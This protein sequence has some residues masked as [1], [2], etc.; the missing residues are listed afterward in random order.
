MKNIT[1]LSFLF[2]TQVCAAQKTHKLD[3]LFTQLYNQQQFNGNVLVME[4]GQ[5]ILKKSY[6]LADVAHQQ[7]L[8]ENSV[9]DVGSLTKQFTAMAIVLLKERNQLAYTDKLSKYIPELAFYGDITLKNLLNHT[10]G[11][12]DYMELMD[13][14]WDHKKIATNQDVIHL[15]QQAQ[16]SLSFTPSSKHEYS[17]T[18][19]LLLATVIERVSKQSYPEFLAKNIFK[20][21][22]MT[23]TLV[24]H[25]RLHPKKLKDYAYGYVFDNT[26][27]WVVAD[28]L[29]EMDYV[30]YLDGLYGEGAI[31]STLHD[32][33]KWY[34]AIKTHRLISPETLREITT[35]DPLTDGTPTGYSFGWRVINNDEQFILYHS[36]FWPGYVSYLEM[37]LKND[38]FF[39]VLQNF[40]NGMLVSKNIREILQD[41]PL[42]PIYKKQ[43]T[44]N[45]TQLQKWVGDYVDKEDNS[46]VHHIKMRDNRLVYNSTQQAWEMFFYPQSENK[47]FYK[48]NRMNLELEF[49]PTADHKTEMRL[50][51]NGQ[52]IGSALSK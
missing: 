50:L 14:K 3:S 23:H 28:S 34:N 4:K 35:P 36:G 40:H 16:D 32:L 1:I 2:I 46:A 49:V 41:K 30:T 24:Y 22:Q 48:S 18:G 12:P 37:D 25:K 44:L 51:E 20:P 10:S 5:E 6:G 9:F 39:A 43:V 19:Y 29:P 27:N 21:L 15:L 38:R 13:T 52:E 47:F 26:Y 42:S 8:N 17:N 31:H 7:A 11:L 33:A 45:E